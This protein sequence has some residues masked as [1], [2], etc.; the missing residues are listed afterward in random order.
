LIRAHHILFA[1]ARREGMLSQYAGTV[2]LGFST[3][4]LLVSVSLAA[5]ADFHPEGYDKDCNLCMFTN[6][7]LIKAPVLIIIPSFSAIWGHVILIPTV[8][9]RDLVL[10]AGSCR[11]PPC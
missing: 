9:C 2:L 6:S 1:K 3:V 11:A 5:A 10:Y 4:A 7:P 8:L